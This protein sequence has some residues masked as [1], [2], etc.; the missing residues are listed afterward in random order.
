M[1]FDIVVPPR[2]DRERWGFD[3]DV[4]EPPLALVAEAGIR[5][6]AAT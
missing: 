6:V 1:I 2:D 5:F 3:G 4:M